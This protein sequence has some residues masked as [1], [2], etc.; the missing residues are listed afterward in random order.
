MFIVLDPIG[1]L[2]L[3]NFQNV[4]F[5]LERPVKLMTIRFVPSLDVFNLS[6]SNTISDRVPERHQRESNPGLVAPRASASASA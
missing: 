6:N 2:R 4:D 3:P 1:D 5:H